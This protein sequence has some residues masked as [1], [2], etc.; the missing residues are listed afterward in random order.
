MR[1]DGLTYTLSVLVKISST[2]GELDMGGVGGGEVLYS[3]ETEDRVWEGV[4]VVGEVQV[5]GRVV[6][7]GAEADTEA[8]R[9][10]GRVD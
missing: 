9:T 1:G 3:E 10:S 6:G 5:A 8:L 4:C 7:E 2:D